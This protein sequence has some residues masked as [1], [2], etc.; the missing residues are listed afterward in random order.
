MTQYPRLA[1][2]QLELTEGM[3]FM[4]TEDGRYPLDDVNAFFKSLPSD[5]CHSPRTW[6][7]YA[8]DI[9]AYLTFLHDVYGIHWLDADNSHVT[10][11]WEVRRGSEAE[12]LNL[13]IGGSS[14]NRAL[15]ALERLYRFAMEEGW[16]V[17]TPFRYRD[18]AAHTS[19]NGAPA[20]VKRNRLR[21][22][23]HDSGDTTL[24]HS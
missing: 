6:T 4:V 10:R 13:K 19:R 16:I 17:Q 12:R 3:P 15:A 23:D 5:G 1:R 20:S 11:Y 14:W 9:D 22:P 21:D 2:Q 8:R 18:I 7:A 24:H